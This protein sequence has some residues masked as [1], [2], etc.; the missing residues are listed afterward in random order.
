MFIHPFCSFTTIFRQ[1]RRSLHIPT[2][3]PCGL[4]LPR[5]PTWHLFGK[6][7]TRKAPWTPTNPLE[8]KANLLTIFFNWMFHQ[9][10]K[11]EKYPS[12]PSKPL[13]SHLIPSNTSAVPT[14]D[15]SPLA[16]RCIRRE[17]M[18]RPRGRTGRRHPVEVGGDFPP[19]RCSS[20]APGQTGHT[21]G[22]DP[23]TKRSFLAGRR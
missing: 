14:W 1:R 8:R 20:V 10:N 11:H 19:S 12:K 17:A 2:P 22:A 4:S 16:D 21:A 9:H 3:S 18:L 7:S 15:K 23:L 6:Y 13:P 5:A